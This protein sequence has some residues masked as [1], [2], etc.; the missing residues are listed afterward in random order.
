M[1]LW[2]A[3]AVAKA[4]MD[5]GVARQP[6]PTS[7]S[8]ASSSRPGSGKSREVM[9]IIIHKAQQQ[10]KR[11][12]FPEGE[13]DK[14]LR[15]AQILIDDEIAVPILLGDEAV[16]AAEDLRPGARPRRGRDHRARGVARSPSRMRLPTMRL[17]QRKGVTRFEAE[18]NMNMRNEL[19]GM[20]DGRS[21][22]RRRR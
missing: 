8:T 16:I 22:R 20:H 4:A 10:P 21:G 5:T 17:R 18:R 2:E 11:I 13:E 15:A 1:L 9:R 12:V 19:F 14:I 3:P 6:I 7:T